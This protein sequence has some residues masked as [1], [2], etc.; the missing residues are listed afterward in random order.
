MIHQHGFGNST[1]LERF[2]QL[3]ADGFAMRAAIGGQRNQIAAMVVQHGERPHRLRPSLGSLKVH[4]PQ[5]VRLT[6]LEALHGWRAPFLLTH[7]IVAQQ[8]AM[9][10]IAGQ[11]MPSRASNTRSL[12]AP[13]SG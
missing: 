11:I 13:Q 2:L 1:S 9:D 4:L 6:T 3:L 7:Q 5:F 12:R 10:G 8:N